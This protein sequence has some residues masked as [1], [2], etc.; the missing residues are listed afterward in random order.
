MASYMELL[1]KDDLKKAM[2]VSREKSVLLFKHSTTCPISAEA[3]KQYQSF[4]E[5]D[6]NDISSY[7][8]KVI[9]TRDVSNQIAADTGVKHESPQILLVEDEQVLWHTS[10]SDITVDTIKE[11]VSK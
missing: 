5:A 4:L 8:V 10:H 11:A 7:L 3:Y 6:T 9:E 2:D 1:N